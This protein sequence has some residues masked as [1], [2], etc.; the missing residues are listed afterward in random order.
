MQSPLF[1]ARHLV[2]IACSFSAQPLTNVAIFQTACCR[3]SQE[4]PS[5]QLNRNHV[6]VHAQTAANFINE[7]SKTIRWSATQH[8]VATFTPG[9]SHSL[10]C[11]SRM[12]AC[13][14]SAPTTSALEPL[15]F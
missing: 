12:L 7:I 2:C 4:M 15:C 6:H 5:L 1:S 3:C 9:P 8:T 10:S 14:H 11:G 13:S